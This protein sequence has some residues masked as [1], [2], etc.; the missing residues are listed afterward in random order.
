[1]A[2]QGKGVVRAEVRCLT[3]TG[4]R[5][6]QSVEEAPLVARGQQQ[7]RV[8]RWADASAQQIKHRV[9]MKHVSLSLTFPAARGVI[10]AQASW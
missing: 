8:L 4:G 5:D 7:R 6:V 10:V 3:V 2:G 1:M 9:S